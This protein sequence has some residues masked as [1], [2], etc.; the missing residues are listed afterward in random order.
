MAEVRYSRYYTYI[1]PVTENKL[2]RSVAPY[3]FSL[4]TIAVLTLFAIRPTISTILNLQ[5]NIEN[6]KKVLQALEE[7][8]RNLTLGKQ[9]LDSLSPEIKLKIEEAIPT[10][11]N[12]S[13]LI[14]NIQNSS[15][16]IASASA[17]QIQP[18]TL[19][20]NTKPQEAILSSLDEVNFSYNIQ[21]DFA[22]LLAALQNLNKTTRLI[23]ITTA[24]MNKQTD[25]PTVL[26][27]AGKAYFLN[28]QPKNAQ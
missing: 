17:L 6:N 26:S 24:T 16:P 28:K 15:S 11:T 20:D 1:K 25:G 4:V 5:K 21:G 12:I 8:G 23:T 13:S 10:K 9:N 2:I 3:I 19:I 22:Q 27:V 14:A 7:K 18:L